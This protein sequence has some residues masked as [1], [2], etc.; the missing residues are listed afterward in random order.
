[1]DNQTIE[2]LATH[3]LVRRE[4]DAWTPADQ[5]EL[6]AWLGQSTFHKVAIIRL[7]TVWQQLVR[8]KAFGAG[9]PK[10]FVSGNAAVVQN[11][12]QGVARRRWYATAAS[13]TLAL[14]AGTYLFLTQVQGQTRYATPVGGLETLSLAD[15][16]RVILNTNTTI[17]VRLQRTQRWIDLESGEAYFSVAKDPSRPFVIFVSKNTVT[18]L[19]T[20]FSVRRTS[21][22]LELIVTEG[23]VQL[24]TT[25][26]PESA[27]ATTLPAGT[28]T[29]I[30]GSEVLTNRASEVEMA[31]LLS[32]RDGFVE[33]RDTT[34]ANAV[35]EFNRYRTRKI[36]IADPSI[37]SVRISGKFRS[38]NAAAFLWLLQKGFPVT[39]E[40][41]KEHT[42][43]RRRT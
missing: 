40:E 43:L 30:L 28:V 24:T 27:P 21:D 23:R 7:D 18:A 13:C 12:R 10:G 5:V 15:G 2:S 22:E 41:E 6:E 19:G 38:A 39:V 11:T 31:T 36:L 35:A 29:R 33:F 32:W 8:L 26:T 16:T 9:V 25:N 42:V 37:A 3:W 34:L 14:V 1:M 17:R 20:E 4:G